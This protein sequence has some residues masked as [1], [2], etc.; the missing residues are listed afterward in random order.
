MQPPSRGPWPRRWGTQRNTMPWWIGGPSSYQLAGSAAA[1]G[2]PGVS[3]H[4]S[5]VGW[6]W[7]RRAVSRKMYGGAYHGSAVKEGR[8]G[9]NPKN[10]RLQKQVL[11]GQTQ[12][13]SRNRSP[14][15]KVEKPSRKFK[16][17]T[18][19]W[20]PWEIRKWHTQGFFGAA[21]LIFRVEHGSEN[22]GAALLV[23]E[24]KTRPTTPAL[25]GRFV[26]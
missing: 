24:G 10:P 3:F 5:S 17:P 1:A 23:I 21:W 14:T 16:P 19:L 18:P 20:S 9:S 4:A 12:K 11:L 7:H 8:S 13:L 26:L 22:P 6:R 15:K 25:C 2:F